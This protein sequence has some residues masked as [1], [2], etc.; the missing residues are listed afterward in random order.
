MH[1][2]NH[3]ASAAGQGEDWYRTPLYYDII[4]DQDT[5]LESDFLEGAY[6]R[7]AT[8][9]RGKLKVLEPAC[10]SGRLMVELASRGHRVAGFD[11]EPAMMDYTQQR[12]AERGLAG[13]VEEG[14]MEQLTRL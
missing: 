14:R 7:H 6:Q 5:A 10:G 9:R 13:D 2:S 4:F 1:D 8:A 3:R 12:L 11:L